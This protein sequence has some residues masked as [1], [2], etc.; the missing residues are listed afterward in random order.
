MGERV[1]STQTDSID[2]APPSTSGITNLELTM[3][4]GTLMLNPGAKDKLV[5][6]S[7]TYNV[8]ALKP[9]VT[10]TG[11]TVRIEQEKSGYAAIRD[12]VKND[13]DLTLGSAP[14]ALTLSIGAAKVRL[15]LGGLALANLAIA[16]GATDFALTLSQPN[17]IE[18]DT[19]RFNAGAARSALRGLGN[20]NARRLEFKGGA[21]VLSLDFDGALRQ[22]LAVSISAAAGSV[23][24]AVPKGVPTEASLTGVMTTVNTSGAWTHSHQRYQTPGSGR[25]ITFDFRMSVGKLELRSL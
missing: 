1:E 2:I 19:L 13:W 16:Q 15:E 25:K 9:T 21:G 12:N 8:P 14:M 6:G 24:V 22:D 7:I 11:N 17:L 10:T 20:L 3:G 23:V 5:H 4:A 18:L